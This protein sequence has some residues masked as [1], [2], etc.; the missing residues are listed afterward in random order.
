LVAIIAGDR[1]RKN[2]QPAAVVARP[3]R[4]PGVSGMA[5]RG[6]ALT[7]G[8]SKSH[9]IHPSVTR[10]LRRRAGDRGPRLSAEPTQSR[11]EAKVNVLELEQPT[12]KL[13]QISGARLAV[14][15]TRRRIEPCDTDQEQMT[16]AG[17]TRAS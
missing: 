16:S 11:L 9:G 1:P 3:S 2:G 7:A 6:P 17:G 15:A 12:I 5:A 4:L 13:I 10:R 8:R 14:S